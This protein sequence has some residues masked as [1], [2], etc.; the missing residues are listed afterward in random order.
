MLAVL[1]TAPLPAPANA[2]SPPARVLYGVEV[3]SVGLRGLLAL[4]RDP[5]VSWWA[6]LGDLLVVSGTD[7]SRTRAARRANVRSLAAVGEGE[8]LYVA[9]HIHPTEVDISRPTGNGARVLASSGVFCVIAATPDG[10]AALAAAGHG[11]IEPLRH[12]AVY[13]RSS[14]NE[15]APVLGPV[16]KTMA[17]EYADAVDADRWYGATSDLAAFGTRY[18]GTQGVDRARDYLKSAMEAAGLQ[19]SLQQFSISGDAAFNVVGELTGTSRP[20]DIYIVCGHY[21]STSENPGRV[22]P[23]AEDNGSGAA[24]V[25]ELARVFAVLRPAATIRFI[26]FSGEEEGLFGSRKYVASL[27]QSGQAGHVRGV[28]NMDM[29]AYS[30]DTDLDVLLET[31]E[32]GRALSDTLAG[33]AASFTSL[34]VVRSFD[35]FGSDHVPFLQNGIPTVLTIENDWDEYPSYHRS[36]DTIGN[37]RRD[38]GG[39]ILRMNAAA[40][41]LLAGR[42]AAPPSLDVVSPARDTTLYGGFPFVIAWSV[43]GDD[44]AGFDLDYSTDGVEYTEIASGLDAGARTYTWLLPDDLRAR[45]GH[46]RVTL[47]TTDGVRI[48]TESTARVRFKPSDGPKLSRVRYSGKDGGTLVLKGR[49]AEISQILVDDTPLGATILDA[50]DERGDTAVRLSGRDAS[51]DQLVP[52]GVPVRVRVVDLRTG[53]TTDAVEFTR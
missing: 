33:A 50:R 41:G 35:P 21:D 53:R 22:A 13:A 40:L 7:A 2:G 8:G 30:R 37:V 48:A 42:A 15:P 3:G 20:D 25:L 43:T 34:R 23:G 24:G 14:A 47:V 45:S 1:L 38:M 49:F 19:V 18:V 11:T 4:E 6:E 12:G 17:S 9:R 39:E 51:L 36:S 26:A 46:V 31:S 28:V 52:P 16:Q 32:V 27:V 29:I 10:A 5:D 44:I